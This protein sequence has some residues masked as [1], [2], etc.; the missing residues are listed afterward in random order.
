MNGPILDAAVLKAPTVLTAADSVA[1]LF[2]PDIAIPV[3][4]LL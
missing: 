3:A 2:A 1:P 4:D